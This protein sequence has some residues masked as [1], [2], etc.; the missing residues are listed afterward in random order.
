MRLLGAT[1]VA[2][3][4]V[5]A[6]LA[7]GAPPAK[8]PPSAPAELIVRF[9][10]GATT[11][12]RREARE[13]AGT[14]FER[15]LPVRGM[16]LVEVVPG[17][18]SAAAERALE[19]AGEVMYAE[20]NLER[21]ALQRP[22]DPYFHLLW[23][24]ENTGQAIRGTA[25][26]A[27]AD[28]DVAE[29]WSEEARG[30]T[31][32]AVVDSGVEGVHPDLLPN[33]W[34]NAGETG[35][36][37]ESN[38]VDDDGN[39]RVDDWRGWDFVAG[40]NDPADENGHGTHVAGTVGAERGNGIGVAGVADDSAL[41]PLRVLDADGSGTVA[42]LILAYS[43]A[44]AAGARVVNLSLGAPGASL[45]ERDAIAA[46]PE[47][48]F[49]AAAGNGGADGVGDDNDITP[50][51]PC[52]Y[53]L[54]N[55]VCVGASDNRD[56]LASF[57]N[58]GATSVDLAAPGVDVASTWPGGAY[59]W[60]SGTSM[61]TPLVAGAAALL[62][63][64]APGASMAD[65]RGA[66]LSGADAAQAFEGRTLTGGRLNVLRSLRLLADVGVGSPAP[67]PP[68]AGSSAA[69]PGQPAPEGTAPPADGSAS[70]PVAGS[71]AP[72]PALRDATAPRL[73]LR[74]R[75]AHGATAL[76]RD[77]L[78]ARIASSER[79]VVR[80]ALRTRGGSVVTVAARAALAPRTARRIRVRLTRAGRRLVRSR[81][82]ARLTLVAR[83]VDPAGNA[84]AV[85]VPIRV[86]G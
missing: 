63:G 32:A 20:P 67:A 58:Y 8:A 12:E 81:R 83:G 16:Q 19:R 26:T 62:W 31:V 24:M 42:D 22:D 75:E 11:A 76:L 1:L 86:T 37:R 38:G 61:A 73:S 7:G 43:Y 44:A 2:I 30:A 71:P 70:P 4:V 56:G 69:E 52:A 79:C 18:S 49:V 35:S 51:Y 72:A 78:V 41:M 60:S 3:A 55:I 59:S 36:G 74:T 27:D 28:S 77:G 80:L 25:G 34:R 10:P 33:M 45:A 64:A 66:L 84:R 9:E 54:P 29:A 50:T 13:A 85:R 14:A 23:G 46:H 15:A 57:S 5:L 68:P 82:A 39:G 65:V 21:R 47:V 17:R 40:D 6:V 53:A 48:L